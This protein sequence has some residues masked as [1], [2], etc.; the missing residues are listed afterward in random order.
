MWVLVLKHCH[1]HFLPEF[2]KYENEI[3]KWKHGNSFCRNLLLT[4]EGA[5]TPI[6][7]CAYIQR[8]YLLSSDGCKYGKQ[9]G[10]GIYCVVSWVGVFLTNGGSSFRLLCW[11]TLNF[12]FV[13]GERSSPAGYWR[14][15]SINKKRKKVTFF[16]SHISKKKYLSKDSLVEKLSALAVIN[17]KVAG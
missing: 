8:L 12:A 9:K 14:L 6:V 2:G 13:F 7:N 10:F 11:W 1:L 15:E 4:T 3:W 16:P 5:I 17:G